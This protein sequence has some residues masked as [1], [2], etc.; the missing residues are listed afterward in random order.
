MR[1]NFSKLKRTPD[2]VLNESFGVEG[3]EILA[4]RKPMNAE[5]SD[6]AFDPDAVS[7]ALLGTWS[8]AFTEEPKGVGLIHFTN[9]GRAIQFATFSRQPEKRIAMRFWYSIESPT[10]LRFRPRPDSEGWLRDFRFEGSTMIFG[11]E[12]HS[13]ICTRPLPDE[14][15]DWFDRELASALART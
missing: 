9:S 15:P 4:E 10:H 14:I 2:H 12:G 7:A 1:A 8:F 11:A 3:Q 13:W 6:A 5:F